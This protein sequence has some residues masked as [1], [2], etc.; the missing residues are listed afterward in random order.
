MQKKWDR[1]ADIIII[2]A[3]TAGLY[4][5]IEAR[6]AGESVLILEKMRDAEW[7]SS[8]PVIAGVVDFAGTKYQEERGTKDSPA[9]YA[10]DGV[11]YCG[12]LPELWKAMTDEHLKVLRLFEE[13]LNLKPKGVI[14]GWGHSVARSHTFDGPQIFKK[15]EDRALELGA[16]ILWEHSAKRLVT[17]PEK[18]VLG[19]LATH[20]GKELNFEA[21]KATIIATGGFGRN[22][23]LVKEFGPDYLVDAIPLMPPSHTG[24][25]LLMA[26]NVGAATRH[27]KHGPKA[28]LPTCVDKK[29][30][31]SIMYQGA[32]AVNKEG[33]RYIREDKWYGYISDA[34]VKQ[35]GGF[36][37]L[38]YDDAMR[39]ETKKSFP[40]WLRHKEYKGDTIEEVAKNIGIDPKGLR[41]QVEEYNADVKRGHDTKFER[42]TLDGNVGVPI[43]LEKPPFYGMKC[44]ASMTSFKGGIRIDAKARVLDWSDKPIPRLYAAGECTG[45]FFGAG[46]YI[47]GTMTVMSMSM[48]AIAARHS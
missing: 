29:V 32:I 31:T 21:G 45:G 15:L 28:S 44:T 13:E 14:G 43:P 27:I 38:I 2:G 7:R 19:V 36:F 8:M 11:N 17:D 47:W 10:E 24:D 33:K 20:K 30:D 12:G 25:G 1:T 39:A 48:G 42:A 35:P 3:G 16:V 4:A 26:L 22:L 23:D 18:G 5:A 9:K 37:Y 41:E 6:K 46:T 40:T 34:G